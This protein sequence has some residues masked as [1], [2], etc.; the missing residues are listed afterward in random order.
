MLNELTTLTEVK[1][2]AE[3]DLTTFSIP[4]GLHPKDIERIL[5][6]ICDDLRENCDKTKSSIK[7]LN[8]ELEYV[9]KTLNI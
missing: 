6:L 9:Y 3:K 5:Q 4:V 2:L 1:C 8:E 7:C